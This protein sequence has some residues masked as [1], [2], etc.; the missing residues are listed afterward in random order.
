M[1][2]IYNPYHPN[3]PTYGASGAQI[4]RAVELRG[5]VPVPYP[6]RVELHQVVHSG[7]KIGPYA[8]TPNPYRDHTFTHDQRVEALFKRVEKYCK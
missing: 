4:S 5:S 6:I 1:A 2:F 8:T 3:A 7:D